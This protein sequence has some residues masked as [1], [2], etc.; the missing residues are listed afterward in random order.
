MR[1]K[2]V[3]KTNADAK[4]TSERP[5]NKGK[6]TST[7]SIPVLVETDPSANQDRTVVVWVHHAKI[8][9]IRLMVKISES[10]PT[11]VVPQ[12]K[13]TKARNLLR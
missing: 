9:E 13:P 6:A 12:Q 8:P 3:K 10:P 1:V 4:R 11:F 2:A 7:I 5:E